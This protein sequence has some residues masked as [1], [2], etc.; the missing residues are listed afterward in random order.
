MNQMTLS[1]RKAVKQYKKANRERKNLV[2]KNFL[3]QKENYISKVAKV[4]VKK[5]LI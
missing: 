1:F 2:V 4:E 5:D 3:K